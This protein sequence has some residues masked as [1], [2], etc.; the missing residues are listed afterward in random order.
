MV[1]AH[2]KWLE[3]AVVSSTSSQQ[4]IRVLRQVFSCHGLPEVLVSDNGTAFTSTEFQTFVQRN[5]FRHI[6]SAPYHPATNGLAER[7]VQTVKNALRKTSGDIDTC[8]SRFLFQYRL[9]P[10]STTGRSLA[11][12]LLG[13]KPCSHLDF[14]FPAVERHVTK[15]QERQKENHDM[16]TRQRSFQVGEEVHALNHRGMQW[17]PGKVTAVM[18]PLTLIVTLD[19]GTETRYHVD[20]VKERIAG[21]E[22]DSGTF[23]QPELDPL[24]TI[25]T[26]AYR[27][28]EL[29]QA[30]ALPSQ[31]S[32]RILT[33]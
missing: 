32:S 22:R 8:L 20:H 14:I 30:T 17:I 28:A 7:A 25:V 10:S 5:G 1:D 2:S 11:E 3:A 19:D 27:Q 12:L 15:N 4:V 29:P 23:Q 18:G 13:R 33:L 16:H 26:M 9:T 21:E 6:R 31:K 24:P